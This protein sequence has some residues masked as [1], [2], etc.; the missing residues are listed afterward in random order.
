MIA[1]LESIDV[2]TTFS[3]LSGGSREIQTF[4][5]EGEREKEMDE[6]MKSYS[7]RKCKRIRAGGKIKDE[8]KKVS[9]RIL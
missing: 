7:E 8:L 2:A 9:D 6:W 1:D 4:S 5:R 3:G